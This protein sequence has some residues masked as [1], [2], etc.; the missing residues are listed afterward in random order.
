MVRLLVVDNEHI[1]VESVLFYF[2]NQ[3]DMELECYG[4]FS[5][6]EALKL[7]ERMKIDI[8]VTDINM[9]GMSG[10]ELQQQ[11]V[12]RWPRCKTIFLSGFVE[13]DYAQQALR[14]GGCDYLLKSEGKQAILQSVQKTMA[15]LHADMEQEVLLHRA[16]AQWSQ[17]LPQLQSHLLQ[18]MLRSSRA[19]PDA[20]E[21]A[22]QEVS[23][24]LSAQ[25]PVYLLL[26][27]PDLPA[28]ADE[29]ESEAALYPIQA[30]ISEYLESTLRVTSVVY[31][32]TT[33]IW[34]LQPRADAPTRSDW[35]RLCTYVGEV[36]EDM[37]KRCQRLMD[38][39]VSFALSA[40]STPWQGIAAQRARLEFLFHMQPVL[41][42]GAILLQR[43]EPAADPALYD[44]KVREQ[45]DQARQ[46][47]VYLE[48]GNK[49]EFLQLLATLIKVIDSCHEPLQSDLRA[50]V[51][52]L[53]TAALIGQIN[54]LQL[55]PDLMRMIDLRPLYEAEGKQS[56]DYLARLCALVF[57][58]KAER[59]NIEGDDMVA[60]LQR[61]ISQNL[62][63]DLSLPRLGDLV[64]MNPYYMARLYQKMTGERLMT[65]IADARLQCAQR[66]IEEGTMVNRDVARA[67][68][69]GSEQAFHRFF[70]KMCDMT[71]QEYR[72]KYK[73]DKS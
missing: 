29:W 19:V 59:L 11:V 44:G 63:G 70:K 22:F 53:V 12:L 41:M 23:L 62:G 50:E 37:R 15:Q 32:A 34:L 48:T 27:R 38:A 71:P 33:I 73:K 40:A 35:A 39:E 28:Q 8:L 60:Q 66:L 52:A 30:M 61:T 18:S 31:D 72:E 46:L 6:S 42:S 20:L 4:A 51:G 45:L 2:E 24:P 26:G 25:Q 67:I 16:Q 68:G 14:S 65:Y 55:K 49:P 43:Q 58:I 3:T 54:K 5:A 13:F 57:D 7:M 10:L 17:A 9:P 69:F 47:A 64:G 56:I 1:V 36:A 21:K